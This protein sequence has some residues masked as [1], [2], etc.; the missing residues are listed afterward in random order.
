[1]GIVLQGGAS[2]RVIIY[3]Y[4]RQALYPKLAIKATQISRLYRTSSLRPTTSALQIRLATQSVSRKAADLRNHTGLSELHSYSKRNPATLRPAPKTHT[5]ISSTNMSEHT[6]TGTLS[7][8]RPPKPKEVN[9]LVSQMEAGLK[10]SE[11]RPPKPKEVNDLVRQMEAGLKKGKGAGYSCRR[12]TFKLDDRDMMVHSWKFNDFD[13][14]KDVLPTFARGLF[15]Y[16]NPS[17][18]D[19]E[20]VIRGYDKFFNIGEVSKTKWAWIKENTKGPYELTVKENGCIIFISGLKDDSLLVCSKHSTGAREDANLSHAIA[21]ERWVD[22]HL[23]SVGKTRAELSRHLKQLN[24]TAVFEL[25]DDSFEEHILAYP[26]DQS[27]LYLHGINFNVPKFTTC[28]QG[29]VQKFA[30]TYG[31]RKTD[32]FEMQDVDSLRKFL[33]EAA[34][35]GSWDGKDVEGFVIRCKAR[36]GPTDPS[37]HNWFF[38]YKFEEP[39]LMYRQ[40][41]EVTKAMLCGKQPKYKKHQEVTGEYLTFARGYF[42]QNRKLAKEYQANHGIIKLRD[43]FLEKRGL[44]GS[45]LVKIENEGGVSQD[46]GGGVGVTGETED[47]KIVLVLI[48]S[49]GCGKTTLAI[50][51]S[52]LFKWGHIQNDNLSGS[53]GRPA[54]FARAVVDSLKTSQVAIADR[55][56]HQR[57][58]RKQIFDN[59]GNSAYATKFV[60]LHYV[61]YRPDIDP[62]E[63]KDRIRKVTQGRVFDRGDNHQTIQA[64]SKSQGAIISIMEGFLTR[65]EPVEHDEQPDWAFH[66]VIDLDIE[67]DTRTNLETALLHLRETFPSLIKKMPTKDEMDEA[68]GFALNEYQPKAGGNRRKPQQDQQVEKDPAQ[69]PKKEKPKPIEYFSIQIPYETIYNTLKLTFEALPAEQCSFYHQLRDSNR[70][71]EAFHITLIHRASLKG[72]NGK[73]NTKNQAMWDKYVN[74]TSAV[75]EP[76]KVKVKLDKVVWDGRLMAIA[77]NL[78]EEFVGGKGLPC[79]NEVPHITV[80]TKSPIIKPKESN[81]LLVMWKADKDVQGEGVCAVDLGGV[82]LYGKVEAVQ[83]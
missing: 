6:L 43:A 31:M 62:H 18:R 75:E 50:A 72:L 39:Y 8:P 79:A 58:E 59:V 76:I 17:T 12:T 16:R 9:D 73:P 28:S 77:V 2:A 25:C 70:I 48:A 35:T 45:D 13:Y 15:T 22:K 3:H 41:R 68:I 61:H 40:W 65:F 38:K 14:K 20:I 82:E 29:E 32:Y 60:A 83:R 30:E 81:N 11:P 44:K 46:E 71:Q 37:W 23:A 27:G 54:R 10:L 5:S 78:D 49:I 34:E 69:Q 55:N 33:E 52:R 66:T 42:Q 56:N 47:G 64:A 7:E 4:Q 1:M 51:L 21:G 26:E 67:A 80:G 57:R 74:M 24:A 19:H 53:P 36:E 63:Y